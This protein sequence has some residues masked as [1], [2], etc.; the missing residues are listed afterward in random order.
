MKQRVVK[1][2][3]RLAKVEVETAVVIAMAETTPILTALAIRSIHHVL[4]TTGIVQG[5][6]ASEV[7]AV[8]SPSQ[9]EHPS[10]PPQGELSIISIAAEEVRVQ[11]RPV[12]LR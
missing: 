12:V 1:R 9:P 7:R 10:R 11:I 2:V 6:R 3:L 4:P 5:P 8:R